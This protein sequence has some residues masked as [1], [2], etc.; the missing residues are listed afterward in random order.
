MIFL[1][2]LK[3]TCEK[4]PSKVPANNESLSFFPVIESLQNQNQDEKFLKYVGMPFLCSTQLEAEAETVLSS[5]PQDLIHPPP[6][7]GELNGLT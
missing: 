5:F 4:S 6:T 2:D 3:L 7:R 1:W